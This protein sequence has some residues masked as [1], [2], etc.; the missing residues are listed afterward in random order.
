MTGLLEPTESEHGNLVGRDPRKITTGEWLAS[1]LPLDVGLR[2]IRA[3]CLDCALTAREA[4]L[5]V[6]TACPLWPLRMGTKPKGF[7]E[8]RAQRDATRERQ[9]QPPALR[10]VK[11]ARKREPE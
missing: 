7:R 5:C 2:A 9:P 11:L 10:K 4:R 6:V 1:D 8:A 3:K